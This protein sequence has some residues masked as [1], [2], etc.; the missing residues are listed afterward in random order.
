[1]NM[2]ALIQLIDERLN[3]RQINKTELAQRL[4]YNNT[5]KFI[6]RL[7]TAL[8]ELTDPNH[9]LQ[10]ITVELHIPKHLIHAAHADVARALTERLKLEFKP[11]VNIIH[12]RRLE[13]MTAW[14]R[15]L[16]MGKFE[17][18]EASSISAQFEQAQ[19]HYQLYQAKYQDAQ[20]YRFNRT[21]YESYVFDIDGEMQD[22]VFKWY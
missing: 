15:H 8:T 12:K 2:N 17:L 14:G 19:K 6:R 13:M 10:K 21:V 18:N 11:S 3:E 4:G 20:G 16:A 22:V 1:M 7:D 5:N 9:L